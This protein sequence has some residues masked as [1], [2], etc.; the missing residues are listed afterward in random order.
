MAAG[1]TTRTEARAY[2]AWLETRPEGERYELVDGEV[3]AMSPER[4]RHSLVKSQAYGSLHDAINAAGLDCMAVGDGVS[5]PIDEA[6]VYAPDGL[7]QCDQPLDPDA[8]CADSP[9]I[10][11]D[12][13]S[14]GSPAVDTGR[15]LQ[16]YLQLASVRHCLVFDSVRKALPHYRRTADGGIAMWQATGGR[17]RLDPPGLDL[18]VDDVFGGM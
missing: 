2:L 1:S 14:L 6:N 10:I 7:V 8:I 16:G 13:I 18:D 12:V 11:V 5:A 17:V 4:N 15:K 3:I 9:V